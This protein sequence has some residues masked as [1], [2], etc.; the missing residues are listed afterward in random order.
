MTAV[1]TTRSTPVST[2]SS[3]TVASLWAAAW[4]LLCASFPDAEAR[5]AQLPHAGKVARLEASAARRAARVVRGELALSAFASRLREWETT[6][7][8]ALAKLNPR[9]EAHAGNR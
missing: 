3:T 9:E 1:S 6:A 5:L 4:T 7:A 8:A 2:T